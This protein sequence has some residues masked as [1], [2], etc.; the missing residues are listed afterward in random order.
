[1]LGPCCCMQTCSSC[2]EWGLLSSC[3]LQAPHWGDFSCCGA[4]ALGQMGF[5]NCDAWVQELWHVGSAA[6]WH[7]RSPGTR[8]ATCVPWIGRQI[9]NHWPT[10]EV[11]E[12]S[13]LE[14]FFLITD[15]VFVSL[16]NLYFFNLFLILVKW[17]CIVSQWPMILLCFETFL[18][19]LTNLPNIEI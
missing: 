16:S 1:M 13:F 10:G 6:P 8:N 14:C 5:S 17:I 11:P 18:I 7:V 9:L 19:F 4:W 2:G 3:S 15:C 12:Q